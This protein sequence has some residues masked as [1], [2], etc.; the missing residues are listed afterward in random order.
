MWFYVDYDGEERQHLLVAKLDDPDDAAT[1]H[2]LD[3]DLRTVRDD[4]AYSW[5]DCD[6][7]IARFQWGHECPNFQVLTTNAFI[8][9]GPGKIYLHQIPNP[10]PGTQ[11]Q[12]WG[13]K[14]PTP[15]I[16]WSYCDSGGFGY[17][18]LS[19]HRTDSIL[20]N[21]F[22][23]SDRYSHIIG[24]GMDGNERPVVLNHTVTPTNGDPR[25]GVGIQ[26]SGGQKAIDFRSH[27]TDGFLLD[28][29][30]LNEPNRRG[31]FRA[32]LRQYGLLGVDEDWI[33]AIRPDEIT[34]RIL[35]I[36]DGRS[37]RR[38]LFLADL[39]RPRLANSPD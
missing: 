32:A 22:L 25:A 21:F 12:G 19:Y 29:M 30:L 31:H 3:L 27:S 18:G 24:F 17:G 23:H 33:E 34:G 4:Q 20:P 38:K 10:P 8:R 1:V 5:K 37:G 26:E 2:L 7:F 36:S 13:G 39:P 35:L 28:T 16:I 14:S 6:L 15:P 9:Y 11:P